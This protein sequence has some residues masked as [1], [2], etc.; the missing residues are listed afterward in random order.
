MAQISQRL[1][2]LLSS[3][4][5]EL[6]KYNV[7]NTDDKFSINQ[8]K[9]MKKS[10]L[11]MIWTEICSEVIQ[12]VHYKKLFECN[13]LLPVFFGERSFEEITKQEIEAYI[14]L[15]KSKYKISDA[16]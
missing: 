13:Q 12:S 16:K 4:V 3:K 7:Q 10:C 8:N 14:Y 1:I 2:L 5:T 9:V 15:L 6:E 11:C